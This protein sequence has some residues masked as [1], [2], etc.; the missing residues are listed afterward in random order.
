MKENDPLVID[1]GKIQTFDRLMMQ[2]N[3]QNGQHIRQGMWEYWD[4]NK[5]QL[6][7]TFSTV[8]HKRLLRFNAIETSKLRLTITG[9]INGNEIQLSDL[10]IYKASRGE[11]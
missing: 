3:I 5:W 6:I 9:I 8:G 10:G 11:F 1:L 4:G 2:E 7:Q